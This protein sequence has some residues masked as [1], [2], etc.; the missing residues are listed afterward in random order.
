MTHA[1]HTTNHL[2][3][4]TSP[5]LLQHVHNP[6]DW[7]PWG[8][9]ALTR[10]K[11]EDKPIL[12]SIGYSAC[13]WC[14]VM[15]HESFEDPATAAVMNELF[16]NI[17]VDREERP[18]LDKI[19]Q[20]AHS[21]L[22]QRPGG[23][24]LTL[25]L[26]PGDQVPFFAG[27]YFPREPRHGLPA[28]ADLLRRVEAFYRENR[29]DIH[30]QNAS[31]LDVL[32]QLEPTGEGAR[33]LDPMPLDVARR[34]LEDQFDARHGGF[35]KAPKFPHPTSLER[36][37]RHWAGSLEDGEGDT[38]ALEMAL[39]SLDRM[40]LGGMFDQLGGGFCRYST[41]EQWMI[42][43]FEKM[44]YD[45][46]PLLSL[47]SEAHAATGSALYRRVCEETAAWVM[48]EMQAP[49]GGYYSSLDADSE[50]EE[51]RFY[52]WS[53]E[54][55]RALLDAD[56]YSLFARRFGLD[57]EANFE[58]RWNPHVYVDYA[59][60]ADETGIDAE[61]LRRR[62]DTAR[63]RLFQA[64][65]Q[66]VRPGRDEKI[67][68][69]WNGLMIKGMA[70]AAL[71]LSRPEYLDSAERALDF[72]RARLWQDGR[73]LA[74]SKDGRAHLPAY[75]DDYVFLI[76]GILELLAARWRDG[77]LDFAL[78]LAEVVLTHFQDPRG[79]F[80]FTAD[81]HEVLIQRPK[82]LADDAMPSGNGIAARVFGRLGH[83]LGEP[84]YLA[85]AE[86]TL[87]AAWPQIQNGPYGHT[88]LLLALEETLF[89]VQ[90]ILLRCAADALP[91]WHQRAG[92]PY[93]PRRMVFAIPNDARDL[94]GALAE[95][96]PQGR[97]VAYVCTGSH[98]SAPITGL[99]QLRETLEQSEA[100]LNQP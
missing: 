6:V 14:H 24:P 44:L 10:A 5:Y 82:P 88:S 87:Q 2:R 86:A 47:Y 33:Q 99:A 42:P 56:D 95:R 92:E 60:Q 69:S 34:Q 79:G 98:C 43:H 28:F 40:A 52:V 22:A 73:L 89:P 21:L 48:R 35:G 76:D 97:T 58:G 31:L 57:R 16:V 30:K 11:Q 26:T 74:T 19:Y 29:Q 59:E 62:I 27:T 91:D 90:T 66:R 36:L 53:R 1:S 50:G 38:R 12:L 85:A 7:Y 75:L 8:P 37:L 18:D 84:R 65:E 67:L 4:E 17:K 13:H 64:R 39:F 55:V 15:A 100:R 9:D 51:G 72:I 49:E 41:D 78:Q 23:W 96:R 63:T 70:S 20:T 61:E 25:I 45:N 93:A 3:D 94:P 80:F 68:T 54:E 77:D 32:K 81:D 83:L 46:G 71:H